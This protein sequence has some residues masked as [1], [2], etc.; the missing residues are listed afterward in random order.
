MDQEPGC[1]VDRLRRLRSVD[2]WRAHHD[3]INSAYTKVIRGRVAQGDDMAE[4]QGDL[5]E[6]F[7]RGEFPHSGRTPSEWANWVA[8][9]L[10]RLAVPDDTAWRLRDA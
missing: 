6:I 8:S 5:F 4:I 1:D 2:Q 9:L 10:C 3:E 7:C